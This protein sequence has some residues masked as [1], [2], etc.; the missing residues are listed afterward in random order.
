MFVF[1]GFIIFLLFEFGILS[2]L[3]YFFVFFELIEGLFIWLFLVNKLNVFV[4]FEVEGVLIE[5]L[6]FCKIDEK[7]FGLNEDFNCLLFILLVVKVFLGW[8]DDVCLLKFGLKVWLIFCEILLCFF[9]L[10]LFF[11]LIVFDFWFFL[12]KFIS[13]DGEKKFFIVFR[14]FCNVI[15]KEWCLIF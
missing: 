7:Y 6:G 3:L 13:Y 10:F 15:Y 12:N 14:I 1:D 9:L 4:G 11:I 2:L 8:E 5:S